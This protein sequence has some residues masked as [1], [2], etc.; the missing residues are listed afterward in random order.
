MRVIIIQT[1]ED[2]AQTLRNLFVQRGD[3]VDVS[4]ISGDIWRLFDEKRY[5]LA[6]VDLHLPEDVLFQLLKTLR[7]NHPDTRVII[8][9]KYPDLERE[10]DVK[11]YGIAFILRAPF[12]KVRLEKTLARLDEVDAAVP[13][14]QAA[15][16][17]VSVPIQLKIIFPFL[18]LA[19]LLAVGAGYLISRVTLESIEDRFVNNLIEIGRLTTSWIVEEENRRLE[20][21]RAL[22]YTEGIVESIQA[23]DAEELRELLVGEAVNRGEE[24]I[25]ILD[26]QGM[27]LV[28]VR[29]RPGGGREEYEYT[30]GDTTFA[31]LEFVQRVLNQ[32]ADDRGDKYGGLVRGAWGD[33]FYVAGPIYDEEQFVGA[34]LVGRSVSTLAEETRKALLGEEDTFAHITIYDISGQPLATTFLQQNELLVGSDLA[35]EILARQAQESRLRSL[36]I[37]NVDYREIIG[38]WEVRGGY[39]LGLLGA[40]LAENFLVNPSQI[41]QLQIFILATL[42]FLFIIAIGYT[43]AGQI[44]NPLSEVVAA[45]SQISQGNWDTTV[46]VSGNDEL[47]FLGFAFN[48]M[49]SHLQEGEIYCDLLGRSVTPQVRDQL[50][51]GLSSGELKLEGQ[52]T[53]A[54]IIITDIRDFTVVSENQ[55]PTTILSWLNQYYGELVPLIASHDGV[56]HEFTG[57]SL[58]AFFGILPVA[59]SPSES[60]YQACRAAGDMI[61]VIDA[62][63]ARRQ[64]TGEPPLITGI[65]VNTGMVAAGGMGSADRLHYAVIGDTVNATARLE[66]LTKEIGQTSAIISE[67]TFE[68]LGDRQGEF[69]IIPMGSRTVKG[70]AESI[71]IYR[72]MPLEGYP[73][74]A[75]QQR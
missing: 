25:E 73:L 51:Q 28:S 48:Y 52:N 66:G 54:T 35:A 18:L 33:Y 42:G 4:L 26:T 46:E 15:I 27:V 17:R 43:L 32:Q 44:T 13:E 16:P 10:L 39:D 11:D 45:A 5:D 7:K 67:E 24:A 9:N 14:K 55:T 69:R 1:E 38:V 60:A 29:H 64:K 53:I 8:T 65:G 36:H 40:S 23:R 68:A 49:V 31:D 12:N 50:R 58:M 47:A 41:T 62:M 3:L 71:T 20:T 72:L 70:K 57:D 34:I 21:L 61:R 22:A 63:S 56:T 2:S 75:G 19:L 59:L 30:K 74:K 37:A 6:V